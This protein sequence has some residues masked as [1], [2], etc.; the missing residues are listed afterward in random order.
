MSLKIMWG[1]NAPWCHTGYGVQAKYVLPRLA[2]L[3][4]D[5]ACFAWYGLE[6]AHFTMRMDGEPIPV[7]PKHRDEFGR[8]VVGAHCRH[9]GADLFV[10]LM[11]IWVLPPNFRD[12]CGCAW[13]PWF[14]VD[15]EPIP[16]AVLE[17]A[18]AADFP[19]VYSR[20]GLREMGNAN[21][22][23]WYIP[24]GV[25]T[26]VFCPGD[27]AEA[28]KALKLPQD[29][30]IVDMV[31]ANKGYPAR[32]AFSENLQAFAL[33][34]EANPDAV[35]YLH[36]EMSANRGGLELTELLHALD[37]PQDAVYRPDP[38]LYEV[39]GLE[40]NYMALVYQAS[41]C[42]LGTATNEGFG[43]PILEAQAC[44]C[45]VITTDNTSMTEL[46]WAGIAVP[47][48]QRTYTPLDSWIGVV[49]VEPV[50]QALLDVWHWDSTERADRCAY[51]VSQAAGYDW[52]VLTHDYWAPFLKEAEAMIAEGKVARGAA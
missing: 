31:A 24:H 13:A 2:R 40:D 22:R 51:G 27:K 50:R 29:A 14:P 43:I 19:I 36:T 45:P 48:I 1:S 28:R 3:G 41:D 37:L 12:V 20:F 52:D 21:E 35:L 42:H 33:F 38:Y 5:V 49:G 18:S 15:H 47:P 26:K 9:F 39:L 7:Y 30:Y 10:S 46:T 34:R 44:G 4:H 23:A 16:P 8:D 17:R 11:D 25:D 6:G 32:K